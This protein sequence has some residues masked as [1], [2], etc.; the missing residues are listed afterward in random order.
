M[1]GVGMLWVAV[2]ALA[3]PAIAGIDDFKLTKAIPADAALA[4]HGR[5]HDGQAFLKAQYDRVW[6]VVQEQH[7]ENDLRLLLKSVVE[8]NGDDVEMFEAQ[9]QQFSDLL[10]GVEWSTL[11]EH[12]S[13]FAMKLGFPVPDMVVLLSASPEKAAAN[14]TGL[15]GI[16]KT[17]I[18]FAPEGEVSLATEGAGDAIVHRVT[19]VNA[20]IPMM[21]ML[22]RQQD[23]ILIGFG[24]TMPEQSLT[25][26]TGG[27]GKT[28]A[29]TD[30]FQA[31]F[32]QLPAPTDE[33]VF[34]DLSLWMSQFRVFIDQAMAMGDPTGE[35]I[36]PEVKSLPGKF[37][38]AMDIFDYVATVSTTDGLKTTMD[39]VTVMLP[40]R[41]DRAL[42]R[43][44]FSNDPLTDPLKFVPQN[45]QNMSAWN[46]I[47]PRVI[48][49]EILHFIK[50]NVPDG[51]DALA[52]WE[53]G[54][55]E[56]KENVGIDV[57]ADVIDW[58]GGG[59]ASFT[60]PGKS[61][62]S[63]ASWVIMLSVTDEEKANGLLN[64]VIEMVSPM[65]AEQNGMID[66]ARLEGADGFKVIVH[67]MLAMML[68]QPTFGIYDGQ[69][70]LGSSP[71]AI[72]IALA[73]AAGK[74]PNFSTNE[75]FLKEGLPL[76]K[77]VISVSFSD[78][79]KL[80][81]ELGG[82]LE[83]VSGFGFLVPD[84]ARHPVG[85]T[86]LMV[87]NK[88]GKVCRELNFYQSSS[89]QTTFD[90]K[91]MYTKAVF[92]YREPPAATPAPEPE[93]VAEEVP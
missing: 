61:T 47:R 40:D 27:E 48:Y 44:L 80:G 65:L 63:P 14:F 93:P 13:A 12:E 33:L 54:K 78:L 76:G 64:H 34:M 42:Y 2:L 59:L 39:G 90:G 23:T 32:K 82:I 73:T 84:L 26:L 19:A 37:I 67:P 83:M 58:I 60:I 4:V 88:A 62:Y 35:N 53:E 11:G 79:T 92:N 46:G 68:G 49:D 28:L 18:G 15:E 5:S 66:D 81:E 36:E 31:A 91:A 43:V 69:L 55:L 30:R 1:F 3:G 51:E 8:E 74:E 70:F 25:L 71:K 52:D 10:L 21:L 50:D 87:A 41:Q 29:S 75:R 77:K 9:W 57:E 72:E 24:Q 38:D 86:L 20:P 45:A 56:I 22:A 17:L 89:S 85:R 7:F 6:A 16:L